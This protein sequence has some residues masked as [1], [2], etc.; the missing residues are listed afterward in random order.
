MYVSTYLLSC[1]AI[2]VFNC[3]LRPGHE[4]GGRLFASMPSQRWKLQQSWHVYSDELYNLTMQ[5]LHGHRTIT[6]YLL[7]YS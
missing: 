2:L 4:L 7:K 3:L 6:T 5:C 1:H